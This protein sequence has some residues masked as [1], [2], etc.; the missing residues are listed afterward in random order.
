M[1]YIYKI[2]TEFT[3]LFKDKKNALSVFLKCFRVFSGSIFFFGIGD[4]NEQKRKFAKHTHTQTEEKVRQI[5]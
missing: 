3:D 1:S 2:S 5:N 4:G